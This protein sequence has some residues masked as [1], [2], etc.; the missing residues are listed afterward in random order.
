MYDLRVKGVNMTLDDIVVSLDHKIF[1]LS[2]VWVCNKHLSVRH[3]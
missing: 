1:N 2:T 3:L